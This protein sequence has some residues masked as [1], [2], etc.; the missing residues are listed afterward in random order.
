MEQLNSQLHSD[1]NDNNNIN[2]KNNN[3]SSEHHHPTDKFRQSHIIFPIGKKKQNKQIKPQKLE[4]K[5]ISDRKEE[6]ILKAVILKKHLQK[7]TGFS[8]VTV[9]E[10]QA[11]IIISSIFEYHQ[12]SLLKGNIYIYREEN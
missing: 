10:I 11:C 12:D 9:L 4:S 1:N 7:G 8:L 3:N 5:K 6:N 2:N